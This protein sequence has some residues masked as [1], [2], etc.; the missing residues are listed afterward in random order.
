MVGL[1]WLPHLA[2]G[3]G[4]TFVETD[5]WV[6]GF[7]DFGIEI[8]HILRVGEVLAVNLPDAP[9]VLAPRLEVVFGQPPAH[10]LTGDTVVCAVSPTSSPANSSS[11]RRARPCGGLEL[12]MPE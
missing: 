7:G 5:H 9:H 11:V 12:L 10:S 4:W 1:D 8:E 2:D 6:L 3:L